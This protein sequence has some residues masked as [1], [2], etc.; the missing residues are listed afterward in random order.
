MQIPRTIKI[1]GKTFTV[2]THSDDCAFREKTLGY[3]HTTKLV[4]ELDGKQHPAQLKDTILH[5]IIHGISDLA[6]LELTERQTEVLA[7]ML[8]CVN[9][10]NPGLFAQIFDQ[11]KE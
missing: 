5:E 10:E 6:S 2:K 4:L 8:I 9:Q 3:I 7:S 11:P 1:L